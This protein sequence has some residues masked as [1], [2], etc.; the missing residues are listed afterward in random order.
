MDKFLIVGITLPN[1][2]PG[3]SRRIIRLLEGS[4]GV[5]GMLRA[6]Y[7]H[8]RKPGASCYQIRSLIEEIPS[9]L[10]QRLTLHDHASLADDFAIGGIHLNSRQQ[11]QDC[12]LNEEVRI[13][14]S[15]HS[16]AQL[17][18]REPICGLS[19]RFRLSY[20]TLSPILPSISK[21]GYMPTMND[22]EIDEALRRSELPVVALGGVRPENLTSL[23]ERGFAGAAMSGALFMFGDFD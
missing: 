17:L 13:S 19:D 1:F 6:D 8:I 18:G 14:A 4:A 21:A 2:Y 5:E 11:A 23:H 7:I 16:I 22:Q 20:V 9:D 3:E 10:H 15:L 12:P